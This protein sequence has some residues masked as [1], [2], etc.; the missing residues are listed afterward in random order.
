MVIPT[1]KAH[2]PPHLHP[3]PQGERKQGWAMTEDADPQGERKQGW[4]M[5]EDGDPQG[6]EDARLGNDWRCR[7]A[8]S[9]LLIHA[10]FFNKPSS[11]K[12]KMQLGKK[13]Y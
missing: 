12:S 4:A 8:K 9:T 10:I 13:S 6:D 1:H 11:I 3:L 5:T 2:F 7:I